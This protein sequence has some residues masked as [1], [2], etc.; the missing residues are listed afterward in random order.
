M[1]VRKVYDDRQNVDHGPTF[2]VFVQVK[3]RRE[4]NLDQTSELLATQ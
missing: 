3:L 4:D 2:A 1:I